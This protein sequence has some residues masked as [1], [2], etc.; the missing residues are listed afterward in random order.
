MSCCVEGGACIRSRQAHGHTSEKCLS[1]FIQCL[2]YYLYRH[3]L[4]GSTHE[5]GPAQ[6][7]SRLGCKNKPTYAYPQ[8]THPPTITLQLF[9]LMLR[10]SGSISKSLF[11]YLNVYGNGTIGPTHP[12]MF[13]TQ[14]QY[15]PSLISFL[16]HSSLS[17]LGSRTIVWWSRIPNMI[18]AAS[19]PSCFQ[20]YR[21]VDQSEHRRRNWGG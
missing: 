4:M 6:P 15:L 17:T 10:R 2:H 12:I 21:L 13:T 5:A 14:I 16:K 20:S 11:M 19:K 8:E 3:D 7:C 1:Y 9:N 18:S